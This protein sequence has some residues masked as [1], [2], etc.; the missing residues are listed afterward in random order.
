MGANARAAAAIAALNKW[1]PKLLAIR[2]GLKQSNPNVREV[3][4]QRLAAI[5]DA[6]A[7]PALE[8]VFCGD[9][10]AHGPGGRE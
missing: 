6:A 9:T 1:K 8:L 10:R 4:R 7:I 2:N 5:Q 3:A